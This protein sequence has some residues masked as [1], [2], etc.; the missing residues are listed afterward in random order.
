[1][2]PQLICRNN[3][4]NINW[5]RKGKGVT[6]HLEDTSARTAQDNFDWE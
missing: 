4:S 2:Q 6:G 3:N 5:Q 1:M